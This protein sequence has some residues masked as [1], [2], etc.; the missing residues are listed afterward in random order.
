GCLLAAAV[1]SPP[2]A[3]DAVAGMPRYYVT[4][5]HSRPVA[6]V[7]DSATGKVRT[8]VPLPRRIDPKLSQIA[9][10][11]DGRGFALTVFSFPRTRFYWL[12]VSA[13]GRS[14]RLT[15]LTAAPPPAGGHPGRP[16]PPPGRS[17]APR[18]G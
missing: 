18:A 3:G 6:K 9:S 1:V 4:V 7:R 12:R 17:K 15:A 13:D 5:D 11:G 8:T 10:A 2:P 16:P 14:A